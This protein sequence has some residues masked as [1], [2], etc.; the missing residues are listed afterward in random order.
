MVNRTPLSDMGWL[1][2]SQDMPRA[3]AELTLEHFPGR[4]GY[5]DL[6]AREAGL[7]TLQ[8]MSVELVLAHYDADTEEVER[9]IEQLWAA[10]AGLEATYTPWDCRGLAVRGVWQLEVTSR[11]PR[12]AEVRAT[13]TCQPW[14]EGA[15]R[16]CRAGGAV[17]VGGTR[18]TPPRF[19]LTATGGMLSVGNSATGRSVSLLD[20]Q[21]EGTA[22]VIDFGTMTA[23]AGGSTARVALAS[24]WSD[25]VP[26]VNDIYLTG[27]AGTVT[28]VERWM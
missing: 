5:V 11:T 2:T 24:D 23:S 25:L 22:V 6:S 18:P 9:D 20:A 12:S 28:Y 1:V 4:D 13:G 10:M 21:T 19:E 17:R 15:T 3:T 7:P 14:L 16:T 8:P 27:C 26:G